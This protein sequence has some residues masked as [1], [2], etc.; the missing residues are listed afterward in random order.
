MAFFALF[1]QG[2]IKFFNNAVPITRSLLMEEPHRRIP[3]GDPPVQWPT[4][5][6]F[7]VQQRPCAAPKRAGEMCCHGIDAN[8]QIQPEHLGSTRAD[9][10][11]AEV[12]ERDR[13]SRFRMHKRVQANP[14]Y[15]GET[16]DDP[17][18]Y[19][20]TWIPTPRL[21]NQAD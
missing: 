19:R 2:R 4:P 1:L 21:P 18:R 14:I 6:A 13:L 10:C 3:G 8:D 17:T 9:M 20:A 7:L 11:P 5:I 15:S 12:G 16:A